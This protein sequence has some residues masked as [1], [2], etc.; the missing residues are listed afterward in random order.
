SLPEIQIVDRQLDRLPLLP[1]PII[2]G[3][4]GDD[5]IGPAPIV[6]VRAVLTD[7]VRTDLP[8]A[9]SMAIGSGTFAARDSV[10]HVGVRRR[11]SW[12]SA[13]RGEVSNEIIALGGESKHGSVNS[14]AERVRVHAELIHQG[15]QDAPAM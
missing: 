13:L 10:V 5:R 3:F 6:D 4:P 9:E 1:G 11:R 14:T 8:R 7:D 2:Q 12:S 15:A